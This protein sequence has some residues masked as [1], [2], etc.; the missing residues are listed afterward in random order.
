[1][2]NRVD[3]SQRNRVILTAFERRRATLVETADERYYV[4]QQGARTDLSVTGVLDEAGFFRWFSEDPDARERGSVVHKILELYDQG[5]LDERSVDPE[6]RPYFDAWRRALDFLRPQSMPLIEHAMVA[7]GVGG[8]LDRVW[9]AADG[10]CEVVDIKTGDGS[11]AKCWRL[12]TLGYA[13]LADVGA[14]VA[15]RVVQLHSNGHFAT[16]LR[17]AP[18]EHRVDSQ[19]W[20]AAVKLAMWK[21]RVK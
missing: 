8:K 11:P 9:I 10:S 7:R 19:A 16:D 3:L 20:S 5:D 21:R 17:R 18:L 14:L 13:D 6:L 4:N 15:R 2:T 12:Q 1:M